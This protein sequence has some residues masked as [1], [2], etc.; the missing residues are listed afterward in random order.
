LQEKISENI[1]KE[2][3]PLNPK[4]WRMEESQKKICGIAL[5]AEGQEN[6]WY[7]DNGCFKHMTGDKEKLHSNNALEKEKNVSFGN[8]Y[9]KR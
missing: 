7:I 2:K 4:I 8:D 3:T 5:Y 6:E 1:S 9:H